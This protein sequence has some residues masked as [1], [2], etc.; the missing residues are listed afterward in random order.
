[1]LDS[2]DQTD[3]CFWFKCETRSNPSVYRSP[4][5]GVK[6]HFSNLNSWSPDLSRNAKFAF[7][8]GGVKVGL[9]KSELLVKWHMCQV[10]VKWHF[11]HSLLVHSQHRVLCSSLPRRLISFTT[12]TPIMGNL[13]RPEIVLGENQN[14]R[15]YV[16]LIVTVKRLGAFSAERSWDK[17]SQYIKVR[18]H[19][20]VL[21]EPKAKAKPEF[22]AQHGLK[23]LHN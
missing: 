15:W 2:R 7:S 17:G 3:P 5:V 13:R 19:S 12:L 6:W 20:G 10:G 18:G 16:G 22:P 21:M 9:F 8:G 1:M 4:G 14:I 23:V 11:W